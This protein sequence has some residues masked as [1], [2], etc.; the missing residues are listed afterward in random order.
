MRE[1]PGQELDPEHGEGSAEHEGR[2]ALPRG[3]RSERDEN[4]PGHRDR[5]GTRDDL[6]TKRVALQRV[7]VE[8][9]SVFRKSAAG[10]MPEL[11]ASLRISSAR[12]TANPS[13]GT[14]RKTAVLVCTSNTST[15]IAA[16]ERPSVH[17]GWRR[18][19]KKSVRATATRTWR[20]SVPGWLSNANDPPCPGASATAETA[21]AST[22][23]P[24][25]AERN[26][27]RP[28][29]YTTANATGTIALGSCTITCAGPTPPTFATRARNACQSGKA[30]P[31]WSPPSAT[32]STERTCRSPNE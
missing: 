20:S 10:A 5:A 19:R 22:A 26:S 7:D 23:A 16:S 29:S 18:K 14:P 6:G 32:S 11:R 1:D 13:N 21:A 12:A 4:E 17:P 15:P 9:A 8:L 31:G 25:Q 24:S 2:P 27:A 30:Y 3:E 28:A